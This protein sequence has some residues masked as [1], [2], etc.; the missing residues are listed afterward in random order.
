METVIYKELLLVI[1]LE[2]RTKYGVVAEEKRYVKIIFILRCLIV[3]DDVS[4]KSPLF[5]VS[6]FH[7]SS[8][9]TQKEKNRGKYRTRI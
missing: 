1:F 6:F 9:P 8:Y 2:S 7:D 5:C 3:S 4:Y